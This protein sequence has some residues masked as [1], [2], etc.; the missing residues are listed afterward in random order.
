MNQA[1]TKIKKEVNA[2]KKIVFLIIASL[3]VL[4]LALP[5]CTEPSGPTFEDYIN[6]AVVGPMSFIQGRDHLAGAVMAMNEINADG[7]VDVCGTP[8]GINLL[9]SY[10][11]DG[12][13]DTNEIID[14]TGTTGETALSAVIDDADFVVGGFRTE[15][16][17]HYRDVAMDEGVI[18]FDC[19]AASNELQESVLTDYATYKYWFKAT[20]YNGSFLFTNMLKQVGS[21]KAALAAAANITGQMTAACIVEDAEWTGAFKSKLAPYMAAAL[22]L[23]VCAL[24]QKPASD[25]TDLSTELTAITTQCGGEPMITV[26]VLS[27]PPGKA[28]GMQQD[29]YLPN[30]FT[31]GINVEAQDID[32]NHDTGAEYHCEMDTWA[33]NVAL[34]ATT[35]DWFD[36]YMDDTGRYPT[37]C[38]ATYDVLYTIKAAV[39]DEGL[40]TDDIIAWLEDLNNA[41]TGTA[42]TT[43]Y[44]PQPD[45]GPFATI[46]PGVNPE[47]PFG[48]DTSWYALSYDQA[49]A[50]YP[51]MNVYYLYEY[52]LT[53]GEVAGNWTTGSML[54]A[55]FA[56]SA[57]SAPDDDTGPFLPHDTIYGP[58]WQT[59]IGAQWQPVDAEDPNTEWLKVGWWPKFAVPYP[60]WDLP[61]QNLTP[62]AAG[63]LVAYDLLDKYGN[64]NFAYPGTVSMVIPQ[65]WIDYWD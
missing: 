56:S 1:T 41:Q 16:V 35:L 12:G 9:G 48:L 6:I 15:A 13:T 49:L 20:P 4:G 22:S 57:H 21:A 29:T 18:F 27:G 5:G 31:L 54:C 26:T 33:E 53:P 62:T 59:G 34:T 60:G 14:T 24:T 7:G 19:G 23:N 46:N 30:T 51:G 17:D 43:G 58:G 42:S 28:Y 65:E 44:Y 64:W 3:L 39:E 55:G 32:Y 37:Y 8:Y 50:I 2:L 11:S 63:T 45:E 40:S 36:D 61:A 10:T 38:A 52:G 47:A 25:A